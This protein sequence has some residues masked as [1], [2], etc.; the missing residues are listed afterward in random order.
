MASTTAWIMTVIF[1]WLPEFFAPLLVWLHVG[2]DASHFATGAA[3]VLAVDALPRGFEHHACCVLRCSY[4]DVEM[5]YHQLAS[6][7]SHIR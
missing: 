5:T 1:M 3:A 2:N 6:L 7:V 4:C